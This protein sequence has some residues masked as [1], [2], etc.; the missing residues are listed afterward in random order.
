MHF[1]VYFL[2]FKTAYFDSVACILSFCYCTLFSGF[3]LL[4]SLYVTV[5]RPAKYPPLFWTWQLCPASL[6]PVRDWMLRR[7]A[8]LCYWYVYAERKKV[9]NWEFVAYLSTMKKKDFSSEAWHTLY[10]GPDPVIKTIMLHFVCQ[11]RNK[12]PSAEGFCINS[13]WSPYRRQISLL[14]SAK[15]QTT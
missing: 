2:I 9:K 8:K 4:F 14:L 6:M 15:D 1:C 13:L 7:V 10:Y 5:V 3:V 12:N 11:S